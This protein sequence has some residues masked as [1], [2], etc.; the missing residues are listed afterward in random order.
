MS[1]SSISATVLNSFMPITVVFSRSSA[2]RSATSAVTTALSN[3]GYPTGQA[4]ATLP[5]PV[6]T[7][8]LRMGKGSQD[9]RFTVMMRLT[10][11]EQASELDDYIARAVAFGEALETECSLFSS[12]L[13]Y[14]SLIQ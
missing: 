6:N 3:L 9:D 8:P 1:D 12:S 4:L 7:V 2:L 5:L 13:S 11:P 10:Y 14:L